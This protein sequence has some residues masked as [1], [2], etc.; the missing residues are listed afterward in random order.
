V[1]FGELTLAPR[2]GLSPP[3]LPSPG[4]T[5]RVS[6]QA[7]LELSDFGLDVTITAPPAGQ[8]IAA[9][10]LDRLFRSRC[11]PASSGTSAPVPSCLART[12]APVP[13]PRPTPTS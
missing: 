8:V 5:T 11:M 12:L 1:R 13:P 4:T 6:T 3:A 2:P 7:T 10:E 9:D